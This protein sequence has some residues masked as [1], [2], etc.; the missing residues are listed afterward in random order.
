ML[1]NGQAA[2]QR[3]RG[4][5]VEGQRVVDEAVVQAHTPT[6]YYDS[7]NRHYDGR[8]KDCVAPAPQW[9]SP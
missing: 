3:V 8:E 4:P 6:D 2:E 5:L 9:Q 1:L 7:G